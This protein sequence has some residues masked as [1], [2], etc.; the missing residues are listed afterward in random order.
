MTQN[1]PE[2]KILALDVEWRDEYEIPHIHQC[3]A[4]LHDLRSNKQLDKLNTKDFGYVLPKRIRKDRLGRTVRPA[5]KCMTQEELFQKLRP[6][7]Y[8]A[9]IMVCHNAFWDAGKIHD[10]FHL[11]GGEE[12]S[13][14]IANFPTFCTMKDLASAIGRLD[15]YGKPGGWQK[16]ED[17]YKHYCGEQFSKSH[18]GFEDAEACLKI[19]LK[20][21][22]K[23][24]I[25]IE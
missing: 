23:E 25:R 7:F 22:G 5:S 13:K 11:M 21:Y 6:F 18:R 12:K 1:P 15:K 16:L 4:I 14:I 19:F 8:N 17:A 24:E 3:G 10:L 2:L 9:H 20:A